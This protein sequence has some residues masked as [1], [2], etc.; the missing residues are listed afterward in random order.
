MAANMIRRALFALSLCA[1]AAVSAFRLP[2]AAQSFGGYPPLGSLQIGQGTTSP[3]AWSAVMLITSP[4]T[5]NLFLGPGAGNLSATGTADTAFGINAC[6]SLTVPASGASPQADT[7][8]GYQAGKSI[9]T[10][11]LSTLIGWDAG[12]NITGNGAGVEDTINTAIGANSLVGCTSSCLHINAFGEDAGYEL[13]NASYGVFIGDHSG[14]AISTSSNDVFIGNGAGAG[15]SLGGSTSQDNIAIGYNAFQYIG[16]TGAY[17]NIW[18]GLLA[19]SGSSGTPN[20]GTTNVGIG[21]NAGANNSTGG[22]N[23]F[24]GFNSGNANTTA[25]S[26]VYLGYEAGQSATGGISVFIGAQAGGSGTGLTRDICIGAN[27]CTSLPNNTQNAA[28]FGGASAGNAAY[29]TDVWFGSGY[30]DSSPKNYT[31]HG[32]GASGSNVA[33]GTVVIGGGESTGSANGGPVQFSIALPGS[34]GSSLNSLTPIAYFDGATGNHLWNTDNTY[35]IG[36]SGANRPKNLFL[37]GNI[38]FAG[39]L[40]SGSTTENFPTSGNIVGTTDSQTLTNKTIVYA[41][42]TLTGVAPLA[43]PTFTGV[44][45]APQLVESGSVSAAAWTTSGIRNAFAAASYTD[46]SS[47]GTVT[48]AYTDLFGASTILASNATTYTNYYGSYFKNPVA[49]TNV[50]F[51]QSFAAGFD[52][53][54]IGSG[55]VTVD[56][57]LTA[58]FV[59]GNGS[60]SG[61]LVSQIGH[62]GWRFVNPA[63]T[64]VMDLVAGTTYS[65][66][67]LQLSGQTVTLGSGATSLT[68]G[69]STYANC[70]A[71]TTSSNVVGCTASDERLKNHI[72]ALDPAEALAFAEAVPV[73]LYDFRDPYHRF[74]DNRKHIG[75]MAQD[76]KRLAP[77]IATAMVTTMV[78]TDET[79]DGTLSVDYSDAGPIALAAIRELKREFDEMKAKVH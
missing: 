32:S 24:I 47:S 4:A 18:I 49:S 64:A 48:A 13:T 27:A 45:T 57:G 30:S 54:S 39:S 70:T 38:V 21:S 6:A 25:S 75:F 79:P 37:G 15:A 62:A 8:F 72:A 61:F 11:R 23:V 19:G 77:H 52:S 36:A 46:T 17:D 7:C 16:T 55:A 35:N 10:G 44:V 56:S 20:S 73:D 22:Q 43:S 12:M 65:N 60:N 58:L 29:I 71:I 26:N 67:A 53:I 42:N 2:A 69:S 1:F 40:V 78:S 63:N 50:T 28:V 59:S 3:P 66:F 5:N 74:S 33:G 14:A 41:S 31:L 34:S 76:I 51:T 68:F 9:T